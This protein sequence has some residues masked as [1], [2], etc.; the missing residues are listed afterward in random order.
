MGRWGDDQIVPA[1]W[2]ERSTQAHADLGGGR[3]YGYMWWIYGA[4]SLPDRYEYANRYRTYLARGSGG[5][6]IFVIPEAQL[7]VVHR[8]DTDNHRSVDGPDVWMVVEKILAAREGE[9]ASQPR[10]VELDAEPLPNVRPA[11][12]RP[13]EVAI[14]P[15]LLNEYVGRYEFAPDIVGRIFLYEG[16]PFIDVPG[17]GQA[18]LFALSDS[19][20]F[21]R[22]VTGITVTIQRGSGGELTGLLLRMPDGEMRAERL[23]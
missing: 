20:F 9:P 1:E 3:G 5:H 10:L 19:T 17:E 2:V 11:A 18:E 8:G 15:E 14:A 12:P 6:G 21:I 4:G 13:R 22:A 16:R 23:R 7:V